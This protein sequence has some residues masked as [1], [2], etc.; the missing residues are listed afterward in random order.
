MINPVNVEVIVGKLLEHL[1]ESSDP[2]LRGDLVTRI[3]SA[4]ERFAPSNGWYIS[5][6]AATFELGGDLVRPEVAAN[7]LRLIAEGSGESEE[8]DAELRLTAVD[9][10]LALASKPSLP[11]VLLQTLFWTVGEYGYLAA[12]VPGAKLSISGM[13]DII[14]EIAG[15]TG[16]DILTRSHALGAL[17]KLSAQLAASGS[18][19]PCCCS[20]QR[21]VRGISAR[22]SCAAGGRARRTLGPPRPHARGAAGRRFD[23]GHHSRFVICG[24]V[25]PRCA[26]RRRPALHEARGRGRGRGWGRRGGRGAAIRCLCEARNVNSA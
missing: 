11:N 13:V 5:T 17:G 2:F 20:A 1:A 22:G 10:L 7:L 8:A 15:R 21:K 25:C 18:P 26:E 16:P 4:A 9:T 14:A 12:S 23:R 19:P 6:I 24:W 3:T